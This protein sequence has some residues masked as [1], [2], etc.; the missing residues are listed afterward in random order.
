M[1]S[2]QKKGLRVRLFRLFSSTKL[3]RHGSE[4]KKRKES[5]GRRRERGRK[6]ESEKT[7]VIPLEG[8]SEPPPGP[9][10]SDRLKNRGFLQETPS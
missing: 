6:R 4:R 8:S 9:T 3:T 2:C 10:R 1:G 5:R 7:R